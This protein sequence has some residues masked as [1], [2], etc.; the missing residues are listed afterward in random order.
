MFRLYTVVKYVN[1]GFARIKC[2]I[3]KSVIIKSIKLVLRA[4]SRYSKL[5]VTL[6]INVFWNAIYFFVAAVSQ[7]AIILY[8][9]FSRR[10]SNGS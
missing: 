8:D 5:Y 7:V 9:I 4:T 2:V 1:S 3:L 10:V 6:K